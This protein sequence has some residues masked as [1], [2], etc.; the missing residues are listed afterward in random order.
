MPILL[1]HWLYATFLPS[2]LPI[3]L[4]L[5]QIFC[6]AQPTA[7]FSFLAPAA[8]W[9][10]STAYGTILASSVTFSGVLHQL[11]N[12][13]NHTQTPSQSPK[14]GSNLWNHYK[15]H[16]L[17]DHKMT[18]FPSTFILIDLQLYQDTQ[19]INSFLFLF[20]LPSLP[21]D[22]CL[23]DILNSLWPLLLCWTH[24]A[25]SQ[26]WSN[27]LTPLSVLYNGSWSAEGSHTTWGYHYVN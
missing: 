25:K 4:P 6:S 8:S 26:F 3:I 14:N 15:S 18:A 10:T 19:S 11:P 24:L 9:V 27:Q 22:F 20:F 17:G 21:S 12:S 2:I 23:A 13:D 5:L 1:V 16:T 7:L